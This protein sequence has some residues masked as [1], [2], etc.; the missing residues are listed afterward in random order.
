MSAPS[1]PQKKV[2]LIKLE[3]LPT[4]PLTAV[5]RTET[6]GIATH[7]YHEPGPHVRHLT[8]KADITQETKK[9]DENSDP[10]LRGNGVLEGK[11][12]QLDKNGQPESEV[13]LWLHNSRTPEERRRRFNSL[14]HGLW[15]SNQEFNEAPNPLYN[16]KE[17]GP[18]EFFLHQMWGGYC[19]WFGDDYDLLADPS[20]SKEVWQPKIGEEGIQDDQDLRMV[21]KARQEHQVRSE[22]FKKRKA[23]YGGMNM[24]Q[25]LLGPE[26]DCASDSD[27]KE[28]GDKISK[29]TV[30]IGAQSATTN[31]PL[32]GKMTLQPT[33]AAKGIRVFGGQEPSSN[34]GRPKGSKKRR[35]ANKRRRRPNDNPNG[36]Y[37]YD[38]GSEDERPLHKKAKKDKVAAGKTVA[39]DP[40]WQ[41]Q[42]RAAALRAQRSSNPSN[43][44]AGATVE[45][46]FVTSNED[47]S[48]KKSGL[49]SRLTSFMYVVGKPS[50]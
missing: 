48:S 50:A 33:I 19:P 18:Y 43:S 8:Y 39:G 31:S 42:T 14:L 45:N 29:P 24:L 4:P 35:K 17:D 10:T 7:H 1:T 23:K 2:Q 11:M 38:S 40:V 44:T 49:L 28:E 47:T 37:K 34:R 32:P 5:A 21:L 12:Q 25:V 15:P 30:Q 3:Q 27:N 26:S 41:A 46:N 22:A 6:T 16:P 9:V 13:K 20:R 36:T